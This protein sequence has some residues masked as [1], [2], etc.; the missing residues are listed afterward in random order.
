MLFERSLAI[1]AIAYGQKS[2]SK[3]IAINNRAA[4]FETQVRRWQSFLGECG[5]AEGVPGT[6]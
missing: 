5:N 3:A 6:L 4:P 1:M 2:P